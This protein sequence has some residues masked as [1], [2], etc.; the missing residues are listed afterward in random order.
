[1]A[2]SVAAEVGRKSFTLAGLQAAARQSQSLLRLPTSLQ[3]AISAFLGDM[4]SR[5]LKQNVVRLS[6][7]MR[8]RKGGTVLSVDMDAIEGSDD[9]QVAVEE[10]MSRNTVRTRLS[11][12]II[13]QG[14]G[15]LRYEYNEKT[16]AAY[17]AARM[18]AIYGTNY[19]V[20]SEVSLRLPNFN[21]SHVLDFG[22]GP[23]TVLWALQ[24]VWPGAVAHANL[25]EPSRA[26]AQAC[27]S[28]LQGAEQLPLIKLHPSLSLLSRSLKKT[29]RQ[30]DLVISSYALGELVTRDER[31][32]TVR[33]LWSLTRDLLVLIEPGTPEGSSLV[34][35]MRTHILQMEKK[36]LRRSAQSQE[37]APVPGTPDNEASNSTG[38]GLSLHTECGVFVVAPCAHDGVCPMDKTGQWCHFSQRL[39]RNS[40]QRITKRHGTLPL[41]AYEDEKFS[42]VVLR[43][44]TRPQTPWPLDSVEILSSPEH[45]A[46]N[47]IELEYTDELEYADENQDM[48][49]MVSE[50]DLD[51][52]FE[53]EVNLDK[54]EEEEEPEPL[55]EVADLGAGWA[56]IVRAPIRRGRHTVLDLCRAT[57]RDGSQG[58][59]N[60]LV[61]SRRGKFAALHPQ[62]RKAHWGDLWPC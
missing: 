60:R 23:G 52:E 14:K 58:A 3:S 25:V 56:R 6:G 33:Q 49:S 36:K 53:E 37:Q 40:A 7:A 27:R 24:E 34:R 57:E 20:L 47:D 2:N 55:E 8:T 35:E 12:D 41:R 38:G 26:M 10:Y 43:R 48:D 21:P 46:E 4:P 61:C 15:P 39:E 62:A 45:E 11:K 50:G 17:V 42:F 59:L 28:L 19:R 18:P 13:S 1:M 30:H 54:D 16:T 29:D 44:G 9:A 31:I 22:S 32:S 51:H 5:E